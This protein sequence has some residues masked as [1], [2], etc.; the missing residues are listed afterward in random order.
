MCKMSVWAW[1]CDAPQGGYLFYGNPNRGLPSF[2]F[3]GI[4]NIMCGERLVWEHTRKALEM[5]ARILEWNEWFPGYRVKPKL[6]T[7]E[8]HPA[9]PS[10][11]SRRKK[12]EGAS[13]CK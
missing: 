12:K 7:V 4:E 11:R 9:D 5:D 3:G 1:H 6:V 2:H 8:M 10:T 13:L